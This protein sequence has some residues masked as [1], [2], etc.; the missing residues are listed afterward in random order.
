LRKEKMKK[1]G[2][3]KL[4]INEEKIF[5]LLEKAE[6]SR[7]ADAVQ[8][9]NKA[10]KGEIPSLS[11][12]AVLIHHS[13]GIEERLFETAADVRRMIYGNRM[14]LFAPLYL[15]SFCANDCL[16]CGFRI[17]N[18]EIGRKALSEEEAVKEVRW[19]HRRG[20]R[21]L[22]LESAEDLKKFPI[23]EICSAMRKIYGLKDSQGRHLIDR[24][25][26]NI[27]ATTPENYKKLL[28]AGIGT[29]NL[30]QET[31]HRPT[32]ERTHFKGPKKS[33]ERQILAPDRA[34]KAGIG[35]IGLGVLYGL[36][37]WK[38]E[39][40]AL[41][42]HAEYLEKKFGIG[43]HTVSFPRIKPANGVAFQPPCPVDD[44]ALL[45]IIAITR[46]VLPYAGL[47]ISTREPADFRSKAFKIGISQ[48]SAGSSTEVGGYR[49]EKSVGQFVVAD[50]RPLEEV[51]CG[52]L[53]DGF[54]PSFC[55]ACEYRERTGTNFMRFA[56]TGCIAPLCAA[57]SLLSLAEY[58]REAAENGFLKDETVELGKRA[59]KKEIAKLSP[60]AAGVIKE[61][62]EKIFSG[63]NARFHYI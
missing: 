14:V 57:N 3:E 49:K 10:K 11:E 6:K 38:F 36:Y 5:S 4:P 47:I 13:M 54:I 33:Y 9:V 62:L 31:Y 1:L 50:E 18:P 21:R 17:S 51:V 63:E 27:A 15:S 29:Y 46:I 53:E 44:E 56:R 7:Q 42:A 30:F 40:L 28:A 22:L 26:V 41:F 19:L 52:L 25:N 55:T 12:A 58:L 34:I 8:I 32:Y 16:Y 2:E 35:D 23:D 37:D 24:L 43:P 45:R 39:A 60:F 20:Y 61:S 48:T 59:I